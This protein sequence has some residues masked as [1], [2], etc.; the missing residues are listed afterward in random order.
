M[1]KREREK[2]RRGGEGEKKE[3]GRERDTEGDREKEEGR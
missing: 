2:G 3:S 1:G